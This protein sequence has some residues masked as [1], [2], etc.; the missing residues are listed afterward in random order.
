MEP[1][2]DFWEAAVTLPM[3][4]TVSVRGPGRHSPDCVCVWKDG[5]ALC[6]GVGLVWSAVSDSS[7]REF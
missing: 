5:N 7:V 2:F 1:C 6:A 3:C 4:R